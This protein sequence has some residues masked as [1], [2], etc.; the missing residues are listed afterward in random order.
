MT[1][2]VQKQVGQFTTAAQTQSVTF[3]AA[4]TP[5]NSIVIVALALDFSGSTTTYSGGDGASALTW[6]TE[7]DVQKL[8]AG[9][10]AYVDAILVQSLNT[11]TAVS[12]VSVSSA[13]TAR[14]WKGTIV[15]YELPSGASLEFATAADLATAAASCT[16]TGGTETGTDDFV[17]AAVAVARRNADVSCSVASGTPAFTNDANPAYDSVNRVCQGSVDHRSETS[18]VSGPSAQWTWGE[19]DLASAF[20]AAYS[21]SGGSSSVGLLSQVNSNAGF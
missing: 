15:A 19:S 1:T 12:T 5:G 21:F 3:A 16:A 18:A 8:D 10:G 2:Y 11:P 6:T 14:D 13:A 20:I 4:T 7:H 9:S 17:I